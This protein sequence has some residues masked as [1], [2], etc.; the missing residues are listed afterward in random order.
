L[1]SPTNGDRGLGGARGEP[2]KN[3]N[4]KEKRIQKHGSCNTLKGGLWLGFFA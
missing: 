4:K 2:K 3:K 1:S